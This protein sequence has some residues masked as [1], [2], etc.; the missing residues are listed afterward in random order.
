MNFV[1]GCRADVINP[2]LTLRRNPNALAAASKGV[3]DVKL[4]S[5]K[6]QWNGAFTPSNG[7]INW[8]I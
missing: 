5:N 8:L 1:E 2:A 7:L 6:W 3:L 4:C